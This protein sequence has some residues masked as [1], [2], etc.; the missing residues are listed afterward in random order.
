MLKV[1][2]MQNT[3]HYLVF[4]Y[5]FRFSSIVAVNCDVSV[6]EI[7]EH[8]P[9]NNQLILKKSQHFERQRKVY[10]VSS[11]KVLTG[12]NI[13]FPRMPRRDLVTGVLG[14]VIP[15]LVPNNSVP[16]HAFQ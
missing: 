7:S 3:C 1:N 2:G 4:K 13:I 11:K 16:W 8:V 10:G 9:V 14:E 6:N 5:E 15:Q 12:T